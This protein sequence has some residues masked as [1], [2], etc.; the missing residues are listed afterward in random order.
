MIIEWKG[1][2]AISLIFLV[3]L[4][5]IKLIDKKQKLNPELKG[6]LFHMLMGLVMLTLPYLFTSWV[7]VGV[8]GIVAL[9][10][11]FFLKN[12]KL[13][14]SIGTVLYSVDK[15]SLGE[16]LFT[17]SVFI[18]FYWSKGNKVLFS[19]PILILTFADS[20]AALIGKNYGKKNLASQNENAKS[21]E[22]S[23]MFFMIA[24][25]LSHIPL[26]LFT[27]IGREESLIISAIVGFNVA[28]IEKISHTGNCNLLIPVT[29]FAFV[30]AH[31]GMSLFELRF[32]LVILAIIFVLGT[33]AV[34]LRLGSNLHYLKF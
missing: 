2:V 1:I 9:V 8:L 33:I 19:I 28:L 6:K 14:N 4:I 29:T 31:I 34:E 27:N 26:L 5:T 17:I 3:D 20:T 13:K 23:F 24:F 16:I 32:H 18:V 25:L 11:L 21:L 30:T 7:S 10:F 15:E 12:T 22:G